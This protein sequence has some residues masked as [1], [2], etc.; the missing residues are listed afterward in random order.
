MVGLLTPSPYR[1][2]KSNIERHE[3]A[4]NM[5]KSAVEH[6]APGLVSVEA[7]RKQTA[8]HPSA[9]RTAFDY[10]EIVRPIDRID[11]AH[12]VLLGIAQ[13]GAEVASRRESQ[14]ANGRILGAIDE[15]IETPGFEPVAIAEMLIVGRRRRVLLA[16]SEAP[17]RVRDRLSRILLA[18]PHGE[19][20]QKAIR[21]GSRIVDAR[22]R[23]AVVAIDRIVL[24]LLAETDRHTRPRNGCDDLGAHSSCDCGAVAVMRDDRRH[25]DAAHAR[26]HV[27][28]PS[29]PHHRVAQPHEP[30]V[31]G[32][33]QRVP[34]GDAARDPC[35]EGGR[36]KLV[37][38]IVDFEEE[39]T[40]PARHVRRL[41]EFNIRHIFDHA[42]FIARREIDVLN[43]GVGGIRGI[44]F[45]RDLTG[46][47]FICADVAKGPT[48]EG[49]LTFGDFDMR[50]PR[51]G[52][53]DHKTC[54]G[55]TDRNSSEPTRHYP[56]QTPALLKASITKSAESVTAWIAH[57]RVKSRSACRMSAAL[58]SRRPSPMNA[59]STSVSP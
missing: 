31:A 19:R 44:E 47:M 43:P 54:G 40:I 13:E 55:H 48:A 34:L 27:H 28:F 39:D 51:V 52:L 42:A 11:G 35:V 16:C 5:R 33:G 41:Q 9:L 56:L 26:T 46:Q 22:G 6:A 10:R 25:A 15:L 14:S 1:L 17:R 7:Q 45:P 3:A 32:R 49:W 59:S 38:P 21:E 24:D 20:R 53:Y 8:D 50:N 4:A 23:I 30:A 2:A 12:V 58:A 57:A 18:R 37:A 29:K 36:R